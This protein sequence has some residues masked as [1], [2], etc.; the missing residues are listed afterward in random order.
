[1]TKRF[2]PENIKELKHN[3][4]F[5]FGSNIQG[6]HV[7]GAALFAYKEFEAEMGCGF[8]FCD[9]AC[10]TYAIPTCIRV[11]G[12]ELQPFK[13]TKPFESVNQIKPFVDAFISDAKHYKDYTFYVTK[14]GCGIAG[15]KVSE[16]A[17]LFRPCL[18]MD[19]VILPKEF[20]KYLLYPI[21]I[22]DLAKRGLVGGKNYDDDIAMRF[23]MDRI[24]NKSLD[25]ILDEFEDLPEG[26]PFDD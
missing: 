8:G 14:I 10:R 26:S 16:V 1:M 23:V 9:F 15:F 19:N 20:V 12:G 7:G 5:V 21:V 24:E 17:E 3:E 4:V 25:D 13:I 11:W 22:D 6:E 2:T 18:D